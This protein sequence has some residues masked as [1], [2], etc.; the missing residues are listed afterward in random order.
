MLASLQVTIIR[1]AV[2]GIRPYD[3]LR[4]KA[5]ACDPDGFHGARFVA[6]QVG[7]ISQ[8]SSEFL[9]NGKATCGHLWTE[10]VSK[11]FEVPMQFIGATMLPILGTSAA[12]ETLSCGHRFA[13]TS[14]RLRTDCSR[15]KV[16]GLIT[17]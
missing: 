2:D 13:G 14:R 3:V 15:A 12:K 8:R 9:E 16:Q 5:N 4:N 1:V 11:Q 17:A 10:D 7:G 6:R